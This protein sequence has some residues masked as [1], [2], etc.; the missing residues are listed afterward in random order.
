MS[1]P[2]KPTAY[3]LTDS[4]FR[5]PSP[6]NYQTPPPPYQQ[7]AETVTFNG[8]TP[9]QLTTQAPQEPRQT[10]NEAAKP[11]AQRSRFRSIQAKLA[12]ALLDAPAGAASS[13]AK[14]SAVYKAPRKRVD[15]NTGLRVSPN[16]PGAI[17]ATTWQYRQLVD[18]QSGER[19]APNTVGAIPFSRFHQRKNVDPDTG[20]P[21]PLGFEGAITAAAYRHRILVDPITGE[22]VPKGTPNAVKTTTFRNRRPVDPT[23]GAFVP[24]GTEGAIR[25]ATYMRRRAKQGKK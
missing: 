14:T 1:Y 20:R 3:A 13:V 18:P 7:N 2:P 5:S 11:V 9:G 19:V 21:V 4:Q 17:P 25:Y 24:D 8:P 6:P 15:P 12:P 16:T 10:T 22:R 23:T